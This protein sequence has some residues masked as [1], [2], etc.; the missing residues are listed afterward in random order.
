MLKPDKAA[1][2]YFQGLLRIL[3]RFMEGG[4]EGRRGRVW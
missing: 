1:F 2:R 3:E 4:E